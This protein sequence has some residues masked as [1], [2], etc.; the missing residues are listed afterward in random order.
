[1]GVALSLLAHSASHRAQLAVLELGEA[2]DHAVNSALLAG[3]AGALTLLA[4][5][6]VTLLAAALTWD[7]P[8]REW[9]LAGLTLFY[10]VLATIAATALVRRLRSWTPLAESQ[11]QFHQ[12]CECLHNLLPTTNR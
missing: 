10:V 4:G 9:W 6:A 8:H 3:V 12:D 2:R 1:V 5:F 11:Q 7:S